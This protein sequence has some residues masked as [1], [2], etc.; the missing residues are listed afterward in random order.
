MKNGEDKAKSP[1][2]KIH[3]RNWILVAGLLLVFAA[4]LIFV[5]KDAFLY[6]DTVVRVTAVKNS[7]TAKVDGI[8]GGTVTYYAQ[9]LT[10][11]ILNGPDKGKVIV[12]SNSFT[13]SGVNDEQ[14]QK[15]NQI[16]VELDKK[17]QTG[18][19]I[20]KKRDFYIAVLVE[21]FLLFLLII[22]KHHGGV[23]LF[24][25]VGNIGMFF[26]ALIYYGQGEKLLTIAWALMFLFSVFTLI[27]AGGFHKKTLVAIVSTLVTVVICYGIYILVHHFSE[28]LP[29]EMMEYV[30]NPKDL[31]E[32]FLTGVLL[33]SL[34]AIMD[35]AISIAASVAEILHQTSDITVKALV[36][37]IREMGYDIMGTMINVLF[38][39]YI[40]SG[41]PIMVIKIIN[42]YTMYHLIQFEMIFSI[43][44][45]LMGAIGIVLAIPVSGFFAVLFLQRTDF[46]RKGAKK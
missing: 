32:L 41:I 33:G 15:G 40:S 35:V 39:T 1:V 10:A 20:G 11:I 45:F 3:R 25:L 6:K 18:T 17:A 34:G 21:I 8:D 43:V 2:I 7:V 19:I 28:R 44:R 12:L 30:V 26:V 24:S 38:F 29:Y 9:E 13:S 27:C 5:S 16:F 31:S 23:I 37:S 46:V 42:G 4:V 14:Y 22:N 36:C